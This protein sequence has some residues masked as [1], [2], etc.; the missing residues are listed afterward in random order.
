MD[1]VTYSRNGI[2]MP[3]YFNEWDC[4]ENKC[5]EV[6][7][8]DIPCETKPGVVSDPEGLAE[9]PDYGNLT[10]DWYRS[11]ASLVDIVGIVTCRNTEL[12]HQPFTGMLLIY[13]DGRRECLGTFPMDYQCEHI[14]PKERPQAIY[15]RMAGGEGFDYNDSV[16]FGERYKH[17]DRLQLDKPPNWKATHDGEYP[18]HRV[19]LGH[20]M[21]VWFCGP[22]SLG[23][24]SVEI[25]YT[26]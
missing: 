9:G 17:V 25:R 23:K 8:S 5:I 26:P 13:A 7:G 18:W 21:L 10:L 1:I 15:Y 3:I 11:Y 14:S 22:P 4:S 16:N 24:C 19:K 6:I 12:Q 2:S 20:G